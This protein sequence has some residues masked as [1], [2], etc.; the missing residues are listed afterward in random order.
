MTL[1]PWCDTIITADSF[2]WSGDGTGTNPKNKHKPAGVGGSLCM[3]ILFIESPIF[4]RPV[5]V[6]SPSNRHLARHP[7]PLM[8]PWGLIIVGGRVYV[9][10]LKRFFVT[11]KLRIICRR[12]DTSA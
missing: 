5:F 3:S 6:T 2:K 1:Y 12:E 8:M 10:R 4:K 11:Y 7:A 9:F